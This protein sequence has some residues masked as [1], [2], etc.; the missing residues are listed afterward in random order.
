MRKSW[1]PNCCRARKTRASVSTTRTEAGDENRCGLSALAQRRPAGVSRR[2]ARRRR[3]AATRP[4]ARPR[5]RSRGS[6]TSPPR[7]E[8]RERM[9]FHLAQDRR[10]GAARL[11][12]PAHARRSARAAAVLGNMGRGDVRPDGAHARSRR[13][14]L[15]R[16][17]GGAAPVRRG[18]AVRR[19][20][21]GVLRARPRRASLSQLRDRAAADR[22]QQAR[23]TSRATRR[24]TPAW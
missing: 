3:H 24:S 22:P 9:T 18:R 20:C 1:H 6:T 4:S 23:R 11:S 12:D 17:R 5:A 13:G 15:L 16:L 8:N 19:Q 10:A 7:P 21:G 2:R 14:L